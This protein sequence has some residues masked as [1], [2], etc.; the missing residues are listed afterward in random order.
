MLCLTSSYLDTLRRHASEPSGSQALS[1]MHSSVRQPWARAQHTP[2]P[3]RR[4]QINQN[5]NINR[6]ILNHNKSIT[7]YTFNLTL[8]RL[9]RQRGLF[10]SPS[11][12]PH[13]DQA[14]E[15]V[16]LPRAAV[17]LMPNKVRIVGQTWSVV[18]HLFCYYPLRR[19]LSFVTIGTIQSLLLEEKVCQSMPAP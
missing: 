9:I 17:L 4:H 8:L 3:N 16:W 2:T 7:I 10:Y 19:F 1:L 12:Y 15:F 18:A 6:S 5:T 11:L 13:M 14:R